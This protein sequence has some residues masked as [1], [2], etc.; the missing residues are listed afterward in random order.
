MDVYQH[1]DLFFLY[2][3]VL[4]QLNLYQEAE[5]YL[6]EA[7]K[8]KIYSPRCLISLG[9]CYMRM[10]KY[11]RASVLLKKALEYEVLILLIL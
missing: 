9:Q 10:E 2:G 11:A 3:D 7:L 4:R 5:H 6:L 1:S 8:F